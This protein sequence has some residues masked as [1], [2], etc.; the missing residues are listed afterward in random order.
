MDVVARIAQILLGAVLLASGALKLAHR[1][2]PDQAR[3]FGIPRV[4]AVALPWVE[5]AI[6]AALAAGVAARWAGGAAVVLIVLSTVAV[7]AQ[8]VRG[9]RPPC[10]CFGELS[11]RPAGADTIVRNAVLLAVAV[12]AVL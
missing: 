9:R 11:R 2:W 3:A 6:G 12:A 10:G 4:V 8:L 1:S 5:I 7:A